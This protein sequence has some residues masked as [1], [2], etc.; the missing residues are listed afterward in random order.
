MDKATPVINQIENKHLEFPILTNAFN[1]A[2][3]EGWELVLDEVNGEMKLLTPYREVKVSCNLKAE[4][5]ADQLQQFFDA[6]NPIM[7]QVYLMEK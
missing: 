1:Q 6:V 7:E 5:Y 2:Q 4:N 3:G